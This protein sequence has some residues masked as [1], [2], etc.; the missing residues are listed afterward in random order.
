MDTTMIYNDLVKRV[1]STAI[2][3]AGQAG[4]LSGTNPTHVNP[5]NASNSTLSRLAAANFFLLSPSPSS[6]FNYS[7]SSASR[8]LSVGCSDGFVNLESSP[9][10]LPES[11]SVQP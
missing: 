4:V 7:S 9:K 1:N 2:N 3:A 11:S 5:N 8:K 6:A 10:S